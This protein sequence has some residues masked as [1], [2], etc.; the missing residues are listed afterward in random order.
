MTYTL[1]YT[2]GAC[3]ISPHIALRESGLPFD[4]SKVDLRAKKLADGS[5]YLAVSPKG[6]VPL[7]KLPDGQILAEGAIMVQYIADQVPEKKLAPRYGTMERYRL[8][9]M[10]HFIATEL[11]K[12][13]SPL[14]S[15]LANDDYKTQLKG[16]LAQRWGVL[17]DAVRG[18]WLMG[19]D[20]TVAD[21]Y[22]FYV[23]RSWQRTIKEDLTRWP[24][25]GEY[26]ARLAK[27]P[28]VAAAL[29]VEGLQP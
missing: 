27:R 7:L 19:G 10:L 26:Y 13:T 12:A 21:G 2:P 1:Y 15:T 25:L 29:E 11:H 23:L 9:E 24:K 14:Y 6:Y 20:F 28:S 18:E 5:D 8:N 4:L 22:A 17:Q 3:S 16:R